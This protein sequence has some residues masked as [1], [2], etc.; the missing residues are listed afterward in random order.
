MSHTGSYDKAFIFSN[1]GSSYK[2]YL[3]YR[4]DYKNK[5]S[6]KEYLKNHKNKFQKWNENRLKEWQYNYI[7]NLK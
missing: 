1:E 3:R 2:N 7:N 4:A 5:L 6:Y